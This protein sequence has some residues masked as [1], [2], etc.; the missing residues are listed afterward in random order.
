MNRYD[1][2][3]ESQLGE[4]FGTLSWTEEGERVRGTLFLLGV[5]NPV[6]GRRDGQNLE[7]SHPLRTAVSLLSCRTFAQLCG[8]L[9]SG[10]IVSNGGT[11]KLRGKRSAKEK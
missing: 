11:M 10:K 5:E 1:I 2:I 7:L 9:L 6:S 4:R 3:L 8:D